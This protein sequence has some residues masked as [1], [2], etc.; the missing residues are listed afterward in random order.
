L[1][2]RA[3]AARRIMIAKF[4]EGRIG[5]HPRAYWD[6]R[7]FP[8][9]RMCSLRRALL[10]WLVPLFLI[11]GVASAAFSYYTHGRMVNE[12]MDA[13]MEQLG[14]SLSSHDGMLMPPPMSE[15]KIDKWG[16]YIVQMWDKD[17]RFIGSSWPALKVGLQPENGFHAVTVDGREWRTYTA[18]ANSSGKRIQVLQSGEF[19][20][21]LAAEQAIASIV[22]VLIL[23]P[24]AIFVLW[25][26]A[27]AVSVAV[28]DIGKKA[29]SQDFTNITE[30]PLDR[31]PLEIR[32]LV[33]S[34]NGLLT[35]LRDSFDAKRRFVQDAAHE[36]RTP[37][38]ALSLQ[39]ENLRADLPSE[40]CQQSFA[41]LEAGVQ[42]ASRLVDQLMKMTR[43]QGTNTGEPRVAVDLHA[44]VRE[45]IGA[46]IAV[47]DQR[48]IDLGVA[49]GEADVPAMLT[50]APGDLRS[51]IDNLIEN[52][53]RYTD[54]G[55]VV[56]VRVGSDKGKPFIEVVD[57]GPGIPAEMI[58]R[59][60]DRF[61]R[62]PGST[63]RGSGLGLAIAKA[64]AERCGMKISLRNRTDR[65]GLVARVEAI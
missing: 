25:S 20:S 14:Q 5:R 45:S 7:V 42:R 37:L 63:A 58:D 8:H 31:V 18:D 9:G 34:F 13:Q 53:L 36:L 46:L 26:V 48:H 2:H 22:P 62:V 29:E 41:Q 55:G 57:T 27:R 39:L 47:A 40:S 50:C 61:F 1:A 32:P 35:R 52:A 44:Q 17:G 3:A 33:T 60:F 54:E 21:H 6:R 11:V 56:D 4:H 28:Q 51:V 10:L 30:L 23:L 24:L 43:Q 64:A 15:E 12:F 59:V 49:E 65:S 38:T 16:S 19:R